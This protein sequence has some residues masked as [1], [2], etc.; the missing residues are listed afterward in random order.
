[1]VIVKDCVRKLVVQNRYGFVLGIEEKIV[2][3]IPDLIAGIVR[4]YF[5]DCMQIN[6]QRSQGVVILAL[7]VRMSMS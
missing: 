2:V 6:T 7:V 5:V 1:M 4:R 3:K